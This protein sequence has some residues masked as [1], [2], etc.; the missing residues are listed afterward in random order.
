MNEEQ[1]ADKMRRIECLTEIDPY[2]DTLFGQELVDLVVEVA[3]YELEVLKQVAV[4]A[5]ISG[6]FKAVEVFPDVDGNVSV[7]FEELMK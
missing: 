2:P 7:D 4:A 6:D 3:A 1:Y 5:G